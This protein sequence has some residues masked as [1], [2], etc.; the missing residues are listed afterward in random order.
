MKIGAPAGQR[1]ILRFFASLHLDYK[2][3]KISA[4]ARIGA[5]KYNTASIIADADSPGSGRW[6]CR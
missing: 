2:R 1:S 3:A 5:R 6:A 4:A